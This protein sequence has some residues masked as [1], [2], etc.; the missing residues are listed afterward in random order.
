MRAKMVTVVRWYVQDE[1]NQE[2]SEQHEV[3]W[4]KKE[5]D[6]TGK[7]MHER[8]VTMQNILTQS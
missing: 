2:D 5:A 4:M 8:A 3:H 6:S 7:V 1:M